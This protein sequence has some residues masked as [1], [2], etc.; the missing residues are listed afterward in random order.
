[1][2][3]TTRISFVLGAAVAALNAG[4]SGS[5]PGGSASTTPLPENTGRIVAQ[6]VDVPADVLCVDITT[7][8]YQYTPEVRVDVSPGSTTTVD[9]APLA[10]GW[11]SLSGRAYNVPCYMAP[12]GNYYPYP[13]PYPY[14]LYAGGGS[15]S[16]G[17]ST[18]SS[19][20][21]G[22]IASSSSSSGGPGVPVVVVAD[23]GSAPVDFD[24]GGGPTYPTWVADYT[25]FNVTAG[26]TTQAELR[27]H[28]LG[29]AN[30]T[31]TFDNCDPGSTDPACVGS[32]DGGVAFA[33]D[34]MPAE[35]AGVLIPGN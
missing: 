31:V 23:A 25:S 32:V 1:M 5:S 2:N 28:Q 13:Y 7:S 12:Y 16:G 26:Q 17:F 11:V 3:S 9:I 19:E 4:C 8:D 24:A 14:P 15:S 6:L 27:F 22:G 29:A 35:D 18:G 33:V 34:A 20:S 30:V 10:P 21:S